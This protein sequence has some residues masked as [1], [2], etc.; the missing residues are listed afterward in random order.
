[1][2]M[3]KRPQGHNEDLNKRVASVNVLNG[4]CIIST[5]MPAERE[6]ATRRFMWTLTK[7]GCTPLYKGVQIVGCDIVVL[8]FNLLVDREYLLPIPPRFARH[9]GSS[10][11]PR[12][13]DDD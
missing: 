6:R 7:S 5:R 2:V 4:L 9:P 13:I 1:V 3:C 12:N 11:R 8:F 10:P